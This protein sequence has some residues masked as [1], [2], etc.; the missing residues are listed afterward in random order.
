MRTN[1]NGRPNT[2][3]LAVL[4]VLLTLAILMGYVEAL[5]P[6]SIGIPGVK[7]GLANF[8]IVVGLYYIGSKEALVLQFMRILLSGFLFGNLSMIMYSL[9]GG[10]LSVLI[11]I[12]AKKYGNFS[13]V[14]VSMLGG[15]F[16]NIGQLLVAMWGLRTKQFVYYSPVLFIAGLVTGFLI[17]ILSQILVTRLKQ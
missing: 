16:H 13:M 10:I 4:S 17:G 12:L 2:S 11:M 8:V 5:L 6:F 3:K 7:L 14:G 9:A 15:V 1:Q